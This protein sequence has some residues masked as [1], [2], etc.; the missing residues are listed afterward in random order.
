[1]QEW[2][3]DFGPAILSTTAIIIAIWQS[4]SRSHDKIDNRFDNLESKMDN[5]FDKVDQRF[6]KV[7]DRLRILEEGMAELKGM[8]RVFVNGKNNH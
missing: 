3:R 7:D 5:R 8:I 4:H 6:D 2:L 1:M